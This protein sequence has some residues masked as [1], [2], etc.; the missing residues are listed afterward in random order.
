MSSLVV[1]PTGSGKSLCYQLPGLMRRDQYR[2]IWRYVEDSE[3]R[4]ETLLRHFGDA[5]ARV[6]VR[7]AGCHVCTSI[8]QAA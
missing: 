8:E 3:C 7:G 5:A 4:R 2:V 6:P 1:M